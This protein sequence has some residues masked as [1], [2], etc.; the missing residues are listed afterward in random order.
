MTVTFKRLAPSLF[1]NGNSRFR[2]L[3]LTKPVHDHHL[4]SPDPFASLSHA[5]MINTHRLNVT[6]PNT[7]NKVKKLVMVFAFI[8]CS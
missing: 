2:F 4:Y 8:P 6:A 7:D 1:A 3:K 5:H